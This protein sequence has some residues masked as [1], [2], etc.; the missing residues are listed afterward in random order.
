MTTKIDSLGAV[1]EI[2]ELQNQELDAVSGGLSFTVLGVKVS[3]DA[4][5]VCVET[6]DGDTGQCK[7][8]DG[9]GYEWTTD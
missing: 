6:S 8:R 2:R 3:V 7:W 5:K 9:G 4:N 1:P